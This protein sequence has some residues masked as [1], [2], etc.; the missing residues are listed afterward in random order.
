MD[1]PTSPTS[2]GTSLLEARSVSLRFPGGVTALDGV[3]MQVRADDFVVILGS[4][5]AGKS[6]LLRSLNR[7][8]T[9]TSGQVLFHGRDVTHASGTRLR[10]LRQRVGMVFQQFALVE[11]KT[12]LENVLAGRFR[13]ARPPI[14]RT[15]SLF[16]WFGR[17]NV[18][19]AWRCLRQVGIE[20][21]AWQRVDTLS[22]GQRQRVAIARLLAQEPEVILADEPIASLDPRSSEVVMNTLRDIHESRRIPVVVSLH[23]V[24]TAR[25]FAKR[26][27]GMQSGRIVFEGSVDDLTPTVVRTLYARDPHRAQESSFRGEPVEDVETADHSRSTEVVPCDA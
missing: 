2:L 12:V 11:R 6:M 15:L 21:A 27:I 14:G 19:C 13:F 17:E 26:L 18:E 3:S 16:G 9:P 5:C 24:E 23:Q 1:S 8:N 10:E 4:S 7:L 20:Q 25:R 22:G